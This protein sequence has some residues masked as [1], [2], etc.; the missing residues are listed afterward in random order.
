MNNLRAHSKFGHYVVDCRF[1]V[2]RVIGTD[3]IF[4]NCRYG[5]DDIDVVSLFDGTTLSCS[6]RHCGILP[7]S[8][9]E[10]NERVEYC[11][12]YGFD[13]YMKKYEEFEDEKSES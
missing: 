12:T 1:H 13:L 2:C 7:L 9:R 11:K 4:M 6:L 3:V 5:D 10:A 8:E